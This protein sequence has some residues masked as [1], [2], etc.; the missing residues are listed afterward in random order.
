MHAGA[1]SKH[2]ACRGGSAEA[3]CSSAKRKPGK[4]RECSTWWRVTRS[5]VN[6]ARWSKT[7]TCQPC[8]V[9][10]SGCAAAKPGPSDRRW[11]HSQWW[12][13][14]GPSEGCA[15]AE[16]CWRRCNGCC[17]KPQAQTLLPC[18]LLALG[19]QLRKLSRGG[20]RREV[21]DLSRHN[22]EGHASCPTAKPPG[23]EVA[24]RIGYLFA[25][26]VP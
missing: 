16:S 22:A 2:S 21:E 18:Q 17:W 23:K 6:T 15:H 9:C 10:E 13:V 1:A 19:H 14:R 11:S 3:C 12:C 20:S 4:G 8:C 25:V 24:V 5:K 7:A 26:E